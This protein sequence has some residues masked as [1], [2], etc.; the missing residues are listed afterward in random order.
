MELIQKIGG[1]ETKVQEPDGVRW[2]KLLG[3]EDQLG[4]PLEGRVIEGRQLLAEDFPE[5]CGEHAI[6]VMHGFEA[7]PSD[8]PNYDTMK[9]RLRE[10]VAS[11]LNLADPDASRR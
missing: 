9:N 11:Y 5:L 6:P 2:L 8:H 3:Y 7:M 4:K 10:K 1:P